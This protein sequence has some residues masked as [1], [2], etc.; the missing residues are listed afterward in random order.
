MISLLDWNPL[1]VQLILDNAVV[2]KEEPGEFRREESVALEDV[3]IEE[4]RPDVS[5]Q[6]L[7][8]KE[9]EDQGDI[10][11]KKLLV[12]VPKNVALENVLEEG[13]NNKRLYRV[14]YNQPIEI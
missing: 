12:A 14:L 9:S 13:E 5:L 11:K 4:D 8:L 3:V 1:L 10:L 6:D 2:G 7:D